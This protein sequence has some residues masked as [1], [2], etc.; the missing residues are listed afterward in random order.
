MIVSPSVETWG[1]VVNE[2]MACGLP[3]VVSDAVGCGPD[4]IEEGSTG[5]V[6]PLGDIT[7]FARA[8]E[9]V[10]ALEPVRTRAAIVAKMAVYSPSRTAEGIIDAAAALRR[11]TDG[12][13]VRP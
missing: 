3:G 1:L 10:L 4:L 8:I 2:A 12:K 6:F 11:A 9:R 7:A 13:G 5:A